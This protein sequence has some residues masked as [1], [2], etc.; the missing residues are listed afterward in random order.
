VPYEETTN[1]DFPGYYYARMEGRLPQG[2]DSDWLWIRSNDV[3][4]SLDGKF[5]NVEFDAETTGSLLDAQITVYGY[6]TASADYVE[7]LVVTDNP[8]GANLDPQIKDLELGDYS[9]LVLEVSAIDSSPIDGAN[10]WFLY[11]TIYTEPTYEE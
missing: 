10:S 5:L 1:T 3:G 6:D 2:D 7:L 9:Q 4:G 8:N 11:T